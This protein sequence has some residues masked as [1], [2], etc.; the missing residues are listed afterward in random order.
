MTN[1]SET[2]IA[3]QALTA[4]GASIVT[5][6]SDD[7]TEANIVKVH[8]DASR[9]A[10]LEARE[11]TFAIKRASLAQLAEGPEWGFAFA[12][13]LP[14]DTIRVIVAR[15][16]NPERVNFRDLANPMDWAR[17]GNTIVC[18]SNNVRI[19]YIARITDP[20]RFSSGFVYALAARLAYEISVGI[21]QSSKMQENMW[22]LYETKLAQAA[23]TEG[24]QGRSQV[25]RSS[26]LTG[27]RGVGASVTDFV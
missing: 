14:A 3:N 5:N 25:V 24:M 21:T 7:N 9:D 4:V 16:A 26:K 1:V 10:V 23:A 2:S 22:Q 6:I 17:E 12:Y 18:D 11:W 13:Q 15:Q 19:R 27:I 8:Y 20:V